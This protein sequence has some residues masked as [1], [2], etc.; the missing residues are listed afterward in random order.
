MFRWIV[1]AT[2]VA[3]SWAAPARADG[4]SGVSGAG[5]ARRDPPAATTVDDFGS[6]DRWTPNP[7]DGVDLAIV[8]DSGAH[9]ARRGLRSR[10]RLCRRAQGSLPRSS[11]E[12]RLHVPD[13]REVSC[14]P[15]RVQADRRDGRECLVVRA[16]GCP[17]SRGLGD[18]QDQE[19]A[20]LLRVGTARR[21]RDP[22]RRGDRIRDHGGI[23]GIRIGMDR[24]PADDSVA[25][26]GR[27]AADAGGGGEF[28]RSRGIARALPWTAIRPRLGERRRR[29]EAGS[30]PGFR[31]GSG[32][33]RA[34][35]RL[36]ARPRC[37]RI[38]ARGLGRR[39][40]LET[41][42]RCDRRQRWSRLPLPS[43]NGVT[44]SPHSRGD[45]GIRRGRRRSGCDRGTARLGRVDGELLRRH[46]EGCAEGLLSPFHRRRADRVDGRRGRIRGPGGG[47]PERGRRARD[48]EVG[49]LDRTVPVHERPAPDVERC[50]DLGI[51]GARRGSDPD[52]SLGARGS[53]P[54][55]HPVRRRQRNCVAAPGPRGLPRTAGEIRGLP[56]PG[57]ESG[58]IA[59]AGDPLPGAAALPGESTDAVPQHAGRH[60]GDPSHRPRRP[61][62]AGER[63]SGAQL[64]DAV[65][66]IRRID[67]RRRGYRG[68]PSA[69]GTTSGR[70]GGRR[71]DRESLRSAGLRSRAG[72]GGGTGSGHPRPAGRQAG[73]G[74][75]TLARHLGRRCGA[76][77]SRGVA[78]APGRDRDRGARCGAR[79]PGDDVGA[80]RLH[81]DQSRRGGHPARVAILRAI[82]DPRRR[83]HLVGAPPPRSSGDRARVHRVVRAEPVC[84]R[85]DPLRRRCARARSGAGARQRRRVHLPGGGV[86]SLRP[87]TTR[88]SSRCGR[89]SSARRPIWT[90]SAVPAARP[91]TE[92]GMRA[93]STGSCRRRSATRDIRPSRC[94]PTGTTSSPCAD[95]RTPSTSPRCSAARPTPEAGGHPRRIRVRSRRIDHRD[96][97]LSTGSTTCPAAPTWA[98]STRRRRRSRSIPSAPAGSFPRRRLQ[99][100]F[101]RYWEFFVGRRDGPRRGMRSPRTR[102]ATSAPSWSLAGATA[103]RICCATSS[104]T[105]IRPDGS[106]GRRWSGGNPACRVSSAI[107]RTPGSG[108]TTFDRCS[109]CSPTSATRTV[110][111]SSGP[112][113]PGGGWRTHTAFASAA[114]RRRTARSPARCARRATRSWFSWSRDCTIPRGGIVLRPPMS[115]AQ[116]R[117]TVQARGAARRIRVDAG[118]IVVRDLPA[119][120]T[121]YP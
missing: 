94:T 25:A 115:G 57:A 109:T 108:R 106:S 85:Q 63:R 50:A 98:T 103:R 91:N 10:E 104:T 6:V 20:D 21:R 7:A 51:S 1:G 112:E 35:H 54:G 95:S 23:R 48:R 26:G 114:C 44:V 78:R 82:L 16:Q 92:A 11:R 58:G 90:P 4:A 74:A 14:E 24:R 19:A 64:A 60:G 71:F 28:E 121:V 76:T 116:F 110:L 38:L 56:V 49:L 102:Y 5:D 118:E 22:S 18:V 43:R 37:D 52:R 62:R 17:V 67:V 72:A 65:C 47:T 93:A 46:R 34:R 120:V 61:W 3:V 15:P 79:R 101:E 88:S 86:R 36:G 40:A 53:R 73:G 9:A 97:S 119:T 41:A 75:R 30:H 70:S 105:G 81:P 2:I 89:A 59:A 84:Q 107:C 87:A 77:V 42:A 96:R 100:T 83:A 113:C 55:D 33:R 66:R 27:D 80:A 12:L 111:W 117:A 68:R 39:G 69:R 99:R 32:V 29:R 45:A 31:C 8:A 13:P